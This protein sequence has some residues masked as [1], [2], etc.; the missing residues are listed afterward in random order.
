MSLT[1]EPPRL[2]TVRVASEPY[3]A[4]VQRGDTVVSHR[5]EPAGA[6]P[7]APPA[8]D[9]VQPPPIGPGRPRRWFLRPGWIAALT[10]LILIA[11]GAGTWALVKGGGSGSHPR[12]MTTSSMHVKLR[13]SA[14]M[15]ALTLANA[16]GGAKGLLPPSSCHQQ[17]ATMVTCTT[18]APGIGGVVFQTYPSLTALYAAYTAQVTSLNSGGF[19]ANFNDCG[20]EMIFGEVAW[21]HNFRHPKTYSI[22]QMS[23]GMVPDA[24]A[25]GRVFCNYANG[26]ETFVW[27]QN[28]GHLLGYVSGPVHEDVW[29]WWLNIHHNIG[30]ASS[31][32]NMHM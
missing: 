1:A 23:A 10:A 12:S 16:S 14:L 8:P 25:A 22:A 9:F 5:R 11:A 3:S 29:I 21:N 32:M 27:T 13:P 28:A 19:K 6:G 4:P 20:L 17:S 26:Q 18:P 15:S 31:P 2:P 7:G 24:Q 30:F